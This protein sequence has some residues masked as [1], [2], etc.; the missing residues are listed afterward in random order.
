VNKVLTEACRPYDLYRNPEPV[1][2]WAIVDRLTDR[3]LRTMAMS[4]A[5][6][7]PAAFEHKLLDIWNA[8]QRFTETE[9]TG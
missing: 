7:H 1:D 3:E 9:K 6:R 8:R 2:I 4:F 5:I